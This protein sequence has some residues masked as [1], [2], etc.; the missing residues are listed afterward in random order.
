MT[1]AFRW[2]S[3]YE[4]GVQ[5]MDESHRAL[6]GRARALIEA[7]GAAADGVRLRDLVDDLVECTVEHFE[8]EERLLS[9]LAWPGLEEHL[10]LHN[11]LLRTVLKFKSD[12][13]YGRLSAD[14][15]TA[16]ISDWVLSHI[17]VDD[18]KYRDYL[19]ARGVH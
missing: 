18:T 4:V 12:L 16:F 11:T 1:Q 6:V 17:Q 9:E 10:A 3:D 7:V 5:A 15:A 19:N 8:D 14:A 2:Q 13:R